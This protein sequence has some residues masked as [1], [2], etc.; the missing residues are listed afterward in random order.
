MPEN[1]LRGIGQIVLQSSPW[2]G[3]AI[4][5][6]LLLQEPSLALG[7]AL[8]ALAG[9]AGAKL[10]GLP[11]ADTSAGLHGFNGALVGIAAFVFFPGSAAAFA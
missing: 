2:T 4:L 1:A 6:A 10:L 7:C 5:C 3:L 11:E 9:N 8:G